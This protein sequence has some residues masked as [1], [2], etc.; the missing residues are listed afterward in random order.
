MYTVGKND[1][2]FQLGEWKICGRI[3]YDLRFPAWSRNN[4]GYDLLIYVANWPKARH[5]AW[6]NLIQARAIENQAYC[7]GVNRIGHDGNDLDYIGGSMVVDYNGDII[8]DAKD[9]DNI[10]K[11]ELS[12]ENLITY[13]KKLPFLKDQDRFTLHV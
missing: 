7:I 9:S 13:R 6:R 4:T 10:V 11:V 3:C 12:K 1:G 2:I 8:A 5:H